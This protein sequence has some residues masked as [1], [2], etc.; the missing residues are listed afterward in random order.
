MVD[1]QK[2]RMNAIESFE[3]QQQIIYALKTAVVGI[4]TKQELDGYMKIF[5]EG[6]E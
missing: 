2:T 4:R 5:R 3:E 6:I 1:A